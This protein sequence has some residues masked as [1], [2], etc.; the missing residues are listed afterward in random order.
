MTLDYLA[1]GILVAVGL[2]LFYGIVALAD[3]PSPGLA[4]AVIDSTDDLSVQNP[5][6]ATAQVAAYSGRKPGVV[7]RRILLRMKS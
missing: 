4:L 7:I 2:I 3:P 5:A 6:G 1:L